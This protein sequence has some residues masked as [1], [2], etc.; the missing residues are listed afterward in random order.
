MRPLLTLLLLAC[1]AFAA[2]PPAP[3]PIRLPDCCRADPKPMPGPETP[4]VLT[5]A[6]QFVIDSDVPVIVLASPPG[7]VA[8]T[9]EAGP[10][11][12]RGLFA[13]GGDAPETREFKGKYV[14]IVEAAHAGTCELIVIPTG[15]KSAGE[16][17]RRTLTVQ[18][19]TKPIPPPGP[20]PIDPPAPK[21]VDPPAPAAPIAGPGFKALIV[22][23]ARDAK[24]L[25]AAQY[26]TIFG[27]A[28]RDYLDAKTPLGDDG[29]THEWRMFPDGTAVTTDSK[30]WRDAMARPRQSLPWLIVSD[31]KTGYEG[32]LPLTETD[33]T[34]K[35]TQFGGPK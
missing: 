17:I 6:R 21:P 24:S 27:Q 8:V 35:L 12:I 1:P 26:A 18:D 34:A 19:G 3:S 14:V 25:T 4:T 10:L 16:V 15:A 2:D 31:G 13:G 22:Y 32:P 23:D 30:A 20:A 5:A 9:E 33:I 29:K 7:V 28:T 11:R